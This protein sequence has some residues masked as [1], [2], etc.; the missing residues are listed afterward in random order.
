MNKHRLFIAALVM[1]GIVV[2]AAVPSLPAYADNRS[3]SNTAEQNAYNLCYWGTGTK[4]GAR[5]AIWFTNSGSYYNDSVNVSSDAQSVSVAIRGSVYGCKYG[6]PG[7]IYAT[8]VAPNAPNAALLSG[9]SSTTL[10]RGALPKPAA[11]NWTSQGGEISA[12]LDISSIPL[13][14]TPSPVTT[15]LQVGLYR[16][17]Y[18]NGIQGACYDETINV[19]VTRA[20]K[21]N[22]WTSSAS[23]VVKATRTDGT[24]ASG[25]SI[26]AFPGDKLDWSHGITISNFT[27]G[28]PAQNM[29]D[30]V[31]R[32]NGWGGTTGVDQPKPF[33]GN[34]SWSVADPFGIYTVTASDIGKRLCKRLLWQPASY[35]D[36]SLHATSEACVQIRS[37][38]NYEPYASFTDGSKRTTASIGDTID[39]TSTIYRNGNSPETA[40][41]WGVYEFVVRKND[42]LPNFT[43]QFNR[44]G[45]HG[46][47]AQVSY[48]DTQTACSWLSTAYAQVKSADCAVAKLLDGSNATGTD[49]ILLDKTISTRP[50]DTSSR[51]IGD[52][53]CRVVAVRHYDYATSA[54]A[55]TMRRLSD[56]VC[57]LIGQ[58][59][60]VQ[61][62]GNDLRAGSGTLPSD[63]VLS[64][65]S[66][67]ILSI[68]AGGTLKTYG[69]WGEYSVFAPHDVLG[70]AS[71][72][73]LNTAGAVAA[74]TTWSKLTFS[75]NS[76]AL[77]HFG[78]AVQ[79]GTIPNI[80]AYFTAYGVPN[81]VTRADVSNVTLTSSDY[82][83]NHVVY[84]TG[85][86]TINSSLNAPNNDILTGAAGVG[87]MVII[88]NNIRISESVKN[89]DAWLIAP[90]GII[91]T[92]YEHSGNLT[93]N[94][95][96]DDLRVTGPVVASQLF[97]KRTSGTAGA[98]AEVFD[99]R[100][101]SYIWA[102]R[103]SV[104]NGSWKT[105]SITELPPRY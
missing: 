92:C 64:A 33:S 38:Y 95:C 96:K 53:I 39:T 47:Y 98:P 54:L 78:S 41:E 37:D 60:L 36:G 77:G 86:V 3:P 90:G 100:S 14:N 74:P 104:A 20:G 55:N 17:F 24:S 97:M 19:Y 46:N 35:N 9:L 15:T 75:N 1:L 29:W 94:D 87:Q 93:V 49:M 73:G 6:S 32:T 23:S 84:A 71:G 91:D 63:G 2:C 83:P 10:Y 52:K 105:K 59:P 80:K 25:T 57:V 18:Q 76:A 8:N 21:A 5:G 68:N 12:T 42:I 89:I 28:A 81:G 85:T 67:G 16:C 99:L 43:S 70:I 40:T 101:D 56:P 11:T 61:V 62:W 30:S 50:I 103:I 65:I 69:S 51:S 66:S 72:S 82:I 31:Q 88:A 13:N 34:T 44:V 27:S 7:D 45:S 58:K 4:Y 79:M 22:T 102:H 48:G 26:D